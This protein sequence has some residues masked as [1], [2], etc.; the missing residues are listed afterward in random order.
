MPSSGEKKVFSLSRVTKAIELQ[1][2]KAT[3][4]SAFW[5]RAEIAQIKIHTSGH[6]YLNIVEEVDGRTLAKMQARIWSSTLIGIRNELGGDFNHILKQGNEIVFKGQVNFHPVYGLQIDIS[7]IDLEF[8]LGQLEKR[9]RETLARLKT[10]GLLEKNSQL[11]LPTIIQRVALIASEN[12]AGYN[13]FYKQIIQN[14]HG[15]KIHVTHFHAPVQGDGAAEQIRKQLL[16]IPYHQFD[17]ICLIRGGGSKLDL[18]CFNDYEMCKAIAECPLPVITGIG[19]E[20]DLTVADNV[21]HTSQKTPTALAAFLLQRMQDFEQRIYQLYVYATKAATQ[22][23]HHEKTRISNYTE[24]IRRDP[25]SKC[26]LLRGD[27]S[28]KSGR[29]VR[30]TLEKLNDQKELLRKSMVQIEGDTLNRIK[31]VE[32]PKLQQFQRDLHQQSGHIIRIQNDQLQ[33][34]YHSIEMVKPERTL[35]RGFSITKKDGEYISTVTELAVGDQLETRVFDQIIFSRITRV[36]SWK[37]KDSRMTRL[38]RNSKK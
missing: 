26:Q 9:K 27:L 19:H 13:D 5:I 34:F 35:A 8:N 21:A 25:I 7:T 30:E 18:D 11:Q 17:A 20:T 1:I 2:Q 16:D 37:K 32:K 15:Y 3:N 14:H 12:T 23:L 10:E 31:L 33:G 6:C 38:F 24:V 22:K 28:K 4:N 36:S 29:L